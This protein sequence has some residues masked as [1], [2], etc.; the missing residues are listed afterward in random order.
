MGIVKTVGKVYET[1]SKHVMRHKLKYGSGTAAGYTAS[2]MLQTYEDGEEMPNITFPPENISN[3]GF[4]THLAFKSWKA[5]LREPKEKGKGATLEKVVDDHVFDMF[6]PMPLT[7]GQNVSGRF[8]ESEDMTYNRDNHGLGSIQAMMNSNMQAGM[9]KVA[10]AFDAIINPTDAGSMSGSTVGNNAP[11]A[12]FKGQNLRSHSF[13]WRLTPKN[14]NE[15]VII[16]SIIAALKI[17]SVPAMAN[18]AGAK[19][20]EPYFGGRL[21]IPHT[22]SISFLDD[23][24]LNPFLFK[25]KECF[26]TAVD[27]NYTTQGAWTAHPDGST[28]ETQITISLKEI[29]QLTQ[30]DISDGGY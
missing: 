8:S 11:G 5:K 3:G 26:I 25:T 21:T 23:G 16:D 9:Y 1:L 18:L 15:Q 12:I 6:L 10:G 4:Q 13:G 20:E 30:Q 7:L 28:I 17:A 27:V 29:T 14:Q 22:V 19:E 24:E 2:S